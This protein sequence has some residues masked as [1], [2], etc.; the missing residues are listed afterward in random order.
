MQTLT[1][2]L[3]LYLQGECSDESC[4]AFAA[5]L[6]LQMSHGYEECSVQE[7]PDSLIVW[8]S[9]HRTARKRADRSARLGY[10]F[11]EI[12]RSQY[13][14]DI[15]QIN[16]SKDRR[17]GKPMSSSY[18]ERSH[19]MPLPDYPCE[20]HAIRTFGVLS[21]RGELVAYLVVYR[22]G[23]L[24]LVSQILGHGEHEPNDVMYLLFQG[25]VEA[26]SGSE[27]YFVYNRHDSGTEGLRYFKSK[28]G[29]ERREV[30]WEL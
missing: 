11:S 24:A 10:R 26:L 13:D 4:R 20:R 28:L 21:D 9:G 19:F 14:E 25:V 29:F 16:T 3:P 8:R 1:R 30:S 6:C 23:D 17:Q 27:G 15:Y 12:D 22:S 5:P 18:L 2:T 7:I